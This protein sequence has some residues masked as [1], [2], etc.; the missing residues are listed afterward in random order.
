MKQSK[1]CPKCNSRKIAGPLINDGSIHAKI[2]GGLVPSESY[3][4]V[5]C[6]YHERHITEYGKE[7]LKK[8]AKFS[9]NPPNP[10]ITHCP[11]CETKFKENTFQCHKC[12][13]E[14]DFGYLDTDVEFE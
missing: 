9:L 7:V 10:N 14:R 11:E 3:A 2:F 4:C 13:F 8:K 5:D 6:G 1:K 12:G